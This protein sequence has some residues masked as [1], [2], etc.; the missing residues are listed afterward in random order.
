M[1]NNLQKDLQENVEKYNGKHHLHERVI[2]ARAGRN[3]NAIISNIL[4]L[5]QTIIFDPVPIEIDKVGNSIEQILIFKNNF[6]EKNIKTPGNS[7]STSRLESPKIIR[8]FKIKYSKSLKS[9]RIP[10]SEE[11]KKKPSEVREFS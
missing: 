4:K 10:K 2:K 5:C 9:S 3:R 6:K 8:K 1:M 11:E 7:P